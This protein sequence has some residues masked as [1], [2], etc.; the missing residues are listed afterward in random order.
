MP[1]T[2]T[3]W[4]KDGLSR[5]DT[6]L[7]ELSDGRLAARIADMAQLAVARHMYLTAHEM[8][9]APESEDSAQQA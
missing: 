9:S 3:R 2:K 4:D 8:R 1:G 7:A 6:W 5:M